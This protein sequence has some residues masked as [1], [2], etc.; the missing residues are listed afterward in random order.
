[1]LKYKA[2]IHYCWRTT[3]ENKLSKYFLLISIWSL[4]MSSDNYWIEVHLIGP[5]EEKGKL[6][7]GKIKKIFSWNAFDHMNSTVRIGTISENIWRAK[8]QPRY[9]INCETFEMVR[10]NPLC[11][12]VF[13]QYLT[14]ILSYLNGQAHPLLESSGTSCHN[15]GNVIGEAAA[16]R[17]GPRIP[18]SLLTK[19]DQIS[20]YLHY[21][22]D[23]SMD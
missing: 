2:S 20:K 16:S 23:L 21:E 1:M 6:T 11:I 4:I 13:D 7:R 10:H 18:S 9:E 19:F 22:R 5:R 3:L 8:T 17:L 15:W 12:N 14:Y